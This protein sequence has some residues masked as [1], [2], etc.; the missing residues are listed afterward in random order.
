M[1][2]A[3]CDRGHRGVFPL[4]IVSVSQNFNSFGR[5]W[6]VNSG[7]RRRTAAPRIPVDKAPPS[8]DNRRFSFFRG[9]PF[10]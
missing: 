8:Q 7:H 10:P 2:D 6:L 9:N 3:I 1:A 4:D 5:F